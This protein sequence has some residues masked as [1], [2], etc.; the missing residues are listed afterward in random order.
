M[1]LV[2]AVIAVTLI[3]RSRRSRRQGFHVTAL[4]PPS[5]KQPTVPALNYPPAATTQ[6]KI[7]R[8]L[9]SGEPY[10]RTRN[11]ISSP[12]IKAYAVPNELR[13]GDTSSD[14]NYSGEAG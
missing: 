5:L 1:T 12:V 11:I 14:S 2:M 10:Q 9:A 3:R 6:E 8:T 4:P 13:S 7:R